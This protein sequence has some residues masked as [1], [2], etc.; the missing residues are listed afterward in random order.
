MSLISSPLDKTSVATKILT[1][2]YLNNSIEF[3]L[4]F[5]SLSPWIT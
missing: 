2:P 1:H 5:Y 3:S 4:S